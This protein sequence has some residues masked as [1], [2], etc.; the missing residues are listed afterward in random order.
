M[1]KIPFRHS[2]ASKLLLAILALPAL[3]TI[4]GL[5]IFHQ[6]EQKRLIEFSHLKIQHLG[7]V[8]TDLLVNKL[9]V[10]K[11]KAMRLASDNQIIVPYKL[12]VK[13]QLSKHLNQL[14]D[15]NDLKNI[16]IFSSDGQF[17]VSVG[18]RITK[19]RLDLKQLRSGLLLNKPRSFYMSRYDDE[20]GKRLSIAAFAP[21]LA[22]THVIAH[23]FISGDVTITE[24]FSDTVLISDGKIQ[25]QSADV[26]YLPP[27]LE[28]I[29]S[30]PQFGPHSISGHPILTSKIQIP[31]YKDPNSYL[32]CA[33][34]QRKDA[35]RHRRI[36]LTGIAISGCIL[37]F[38]AAY[39][40][41]LSKRLTSLLYR[42][43]GRSHHCKKR[44]CR[45]APRTKRRD[46]CPE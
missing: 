22:G 5:F 45:M 32:V 39:A 40:L 29:D 8:N 6:I 3:L 18:T 28:E 10:F 14:L 11:E 4:A 43:G 37:V 38:L 36:F 44:R 24:A 15:Q 21:I 41:Y 27:L 23:L 20:C 34:D 13:F 42:A 30:Q 9:V 31:G 1:E 46:R 7:D 33:I 26:P 16:T 25:S 2:L 12:N 19:F 35:M 17:V